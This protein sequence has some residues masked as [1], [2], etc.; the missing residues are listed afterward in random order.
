[1]AVGGTANGVAATPVALTVVVTPRLTVAHREIRIA[2]GTRLTSALLARRLG[3]T[4]RNEG[5]EKLKLSFAA[6]NT[7][8]AGRYAAT[9]RVVDAHGATT[10]SVTV[11]VTVA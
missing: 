2:R 5:S 8:R 10:A 4:L 6:V 3:V 11:H 9:V 1:V 7:K